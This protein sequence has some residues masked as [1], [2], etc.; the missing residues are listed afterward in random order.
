MS[1]A[2]VSAALRTR[3]LTAVGIGTV[4]AYDPLTFDSPDSPEFAT[5]Y[6]A[7]SHVNTTWMKRT[8]V[9]TERAPDSDTSYWLFHSFRFSLQ[10]GIK[11]TTSPA[12]FEAIVDSIIDKFNRS[13]ADT[14]LGGAALTYSLLQA[15]RMSDRLISGI[16]CHVA[17]FEIQ[18]QEVLS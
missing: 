18:I 4:Y 14:T 10:Y 6:V 16:A 9:K 2:T 5:N 8:G 17:D 11:M 12:E 13:A 15:P 1:Y 3:I 7:S